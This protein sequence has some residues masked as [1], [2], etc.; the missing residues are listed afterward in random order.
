MDA[1]DLLDAT[2]DIERH[3]NSDGWDQPSLLFALVPTDRIRAE[4]PELAAELGVTEGGPALTTFEQD[5]PPSDEPLDEFLAR[6][7]WPEQIAGAA[8]VVERV[9]LPPEAE[10]G[11]AERPL[12]VFGKR[13]KPGHVLGEGD[14]VEIYRPLKADPKIVR[15]ELAAMGKTMG[16]KA[17]R[18]RSAVRESDDSADGGEPG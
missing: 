13:V 15:R 3:V 16:G 10:E 8:V 14:R 9:V 4:Q 2:L 5:P 18:E 6:I 11:L 17:R 12:G 7:E 1:Q